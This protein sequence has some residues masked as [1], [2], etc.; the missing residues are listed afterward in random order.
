MIIYIKTVMVTMI[1]Q[2]MWKL[3]Y[4][5]GPH[6]SLIQMF[7]NWGPETPRGPQGNAKGILWKFRLEK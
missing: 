1:A 6:D 5:V 4:P 3:Q 2:Q 7:S